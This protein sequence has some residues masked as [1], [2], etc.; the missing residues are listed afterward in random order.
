[1]SSN[2][3]EVNANRLVGGGVINTLLCKEDSFCFQCKVGLAFPHIFLRNQYF[4]PLNFSCC[5]CVRV[6]HNLVLLCQGSLQLFGK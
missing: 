1:M 4:S 3:H 5:V 2:S 6:L